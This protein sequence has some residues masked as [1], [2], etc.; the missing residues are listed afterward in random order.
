MSS[1]SPAAEQRIAL[2]IGNSKYIEF[3]TL[4]NPANDAKG[5][6]ESLRK[7]GYSTKLVIDADES[8]MRRE[9][10]RFAAV[11][12]GVDVAIVFY[13]GHGAQVNGE[14]YLLPI[15]LDIP[16]VETDIQLSSIKIDDI[17]NS[18]KSKIKII[19]LDACRDNPV[20][21]K[22]LVK[23]RGGFRGGLAPVNP[24]LENNSSEGVF[25]AYATDSGNT[26][27]DGAGKQN[28]P[29]TAALLKSINEPVS[30][31][32]MFSIVTREVRRSTSNTQRP[33]KYASLEG[34]FCIPFDCSNRNIRSED[35]KNIESNSEIKY[36]KE[37]SDNIWTGVNNDD[38]AFIFYDIKSLIKTGSRARIKTLAYRYSKPTADYPLDSYTKS[39]W[40]LDCD[41]RLYFLTQLD[42]VLNEKPVASYTF[43]KW[44]TIEANGDS[45]IKGSIIEEIYFIG[46]SQ[47]KPP[48]ISTANLV[49]F[50]T[51]TVDV[52]VNGDTK[53]IIYSYFYDKNSIVRSNENSSVNFRIET[54]TPATLLKESENNYRQMH[55][56][57]GKHKNSYSDFSIKII[58][59]ESKLPKFYGFNFSGELKTPISVVA[60]SDWYIEPSGYVDF[61]K[62]VVCEK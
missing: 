41:K 7:L 43:G 33:Y 50:F 46:C 25:I 27:S 35:L 3:G 56:F 11:S 2:V 60:N 28:S 18:L 12:Q 17:I 47:I 16:K 49:R 9:I 26:A 44:Q 10:K 39:E 8:T 6:G 31:D 15:D 37:L 5:I 30:I 38:S 4:A 1:A 51:T 21:S 42:M 54:S 59:N 22:G 13:A 58:C 45:P 32:D 14:N 20:L 23:G 29:F 24:I 61:L 36:F 34:I 62:E 53:K 57:Y 55:F 19:F 40:A 48:E 52:M